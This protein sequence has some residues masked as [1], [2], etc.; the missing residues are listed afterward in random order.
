MKT[1][2]GCGYIE[3]GGMQC[4]LVCPNCDHEYMSVEFSEYFPESACNSDSSSLYSFS[5]EGGG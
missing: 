3:Y 4:E 1:C 5:Q 2:S